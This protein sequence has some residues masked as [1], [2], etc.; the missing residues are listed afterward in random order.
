MEGNLVRLIE[1]E[2]N[3]TSL[4]ID[5]T[6]QICKDS[7]KEPPPKKGQGGGNLIWI[8]EKRN[9]KKHREGVQVI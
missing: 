1:L 4:V 7:T 8:K 5:L 3:N 6:I 2:L 9:K